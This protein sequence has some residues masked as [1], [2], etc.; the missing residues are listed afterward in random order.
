MTAE[1]RLEV[2][3]RMKQYWAQRRAQR[4]SSAQPRTVEDVIRR[5]RDRLA[6]LEQANQILKEGVY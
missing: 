6:V 1:Q 5:L 3:R 4:F 2:G